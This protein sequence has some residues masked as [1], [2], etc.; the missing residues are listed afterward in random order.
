[1][2]L[3][4]QNEACNMPYTNDSV[5][6]RNSLYEE[7]NSGGKCVRPNE[8]A[9]CNK[10]FFADYSDGYCKSKYCLFI[11]SFLKFLLTYLRH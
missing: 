5:P 6:D 3:T 9:C 4:N 8:C 7:R 10:G 11:N 2:T 1:M